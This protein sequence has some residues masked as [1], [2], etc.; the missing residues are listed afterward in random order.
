MWVQRAVGGRK[1]LPAFRPLAELNLLVTWH[2]GERTCVSRPKASSTHT[3]IYIYTLHYGCK[4]VEVWFRGVRLSVNLLLQLYFLFVY[5][6]IATGE[7]ELVCLYWRLFFKVLH[8]N[9]ASVGHGKPP[10]PP[11]PDCCTP[12]VFLG[13]S[14]QVQ[15][16]IATQS[17]TRVSPARSELLMN[18]F[19]S[20][21]L[22][23]GKTHSCE[24]ILCFCVLESSGP[25]VA[26]KAGA[27]RGHYRAVKGGEQQA[28]EYLGIPFAAPQPAEPWDGVRDATK[29]P[30]M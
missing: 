8:Q 9:L 12:A 26:L 23:G 28:E 21:K 29:M 1:V 13:S 7:C 10:P 24:N 5:K 16:T 6:N 18:E 27:V 30:K 25:A 4:I 14:R 11:V 15:D 2:G 17:K 19:R 22:L 3:H 20:L